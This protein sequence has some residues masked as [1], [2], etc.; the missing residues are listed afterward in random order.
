M[1]AN[2]KFE[3]IQGLTRTL[4]FVLLALGIVGIGSSTAPGWLYLYCPV[5]LGAF[6]YWVSEKGTS[7]AAYGVGLGLL[8]AFLLV[9]FAI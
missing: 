9:T 1:K 5:T 6:G 2:N 3:V 8:V 4:V 7:F